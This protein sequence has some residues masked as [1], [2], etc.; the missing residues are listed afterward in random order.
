M[1]ERS[2]ASGSGQLATSEQIEPGSARRLAMAV[3]WPAFLLAGVLD[4]LI[5]VVVDPAELRWF[6]GPALGWS[7]LAVYSAT[8]L[9]VWAVISVSGALTAMM[10]RDGENRRAGPAGRAAPRSH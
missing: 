10:L 7:T 9:I 5:F 6:G 3:L 4:A 8:F 1:T 2:A